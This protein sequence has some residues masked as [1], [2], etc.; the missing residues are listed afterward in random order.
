MK[1]NFGLR[2]SQSLGATLIA[3]MIEINRVEEVLAAAVAAASSVQ[4]N[5]QFAYLQQHDFNSQL[6]KLYSLSPCGG[7]YDRTTLMSGLELDSNFQGRAVSLAPPF[8][9]QQGG[10]APVSISPMQQLQQSRQLQNTMSEL[11]LAQQ[12]QVRRLV[13]ESFSPN[14][15]R[16]PSCVQTP[17]EL[18]AK[19][20]KPL[21]KLPRRKVTAETFPMKLMETMTAHHDDDIVSWCPDGKS[22]VV[23][24]PDLFV[25]MIS[26]HM[27]ENCKYASFV[28]KLNKWGF[29]RRKSGAYR[30]LNK[31]GFSRRKS[32][33]DCFYH[34]LFQYD[35][36]DLCAQMI[37]KHRIEWSKKK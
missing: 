12:G 22:F 37:Y 3:S 36:M 28:R 7:S 30:K 27:S 35:R 32:G 1:H 34:P 21:P 24:D 8:Q 29:S 20:V 19:V 18:C 26:K 5:P 23:V 2:S 25:D 6:N 15:T 4:E 14:Q 9:Q 11:L 17:V 33:A 10:V 13:D 16:R 31:W